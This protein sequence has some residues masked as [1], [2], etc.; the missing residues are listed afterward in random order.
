MKNNR[1]SANVVL[2]IMAVAF[3]LLG[4]GTV[5]GA[6]LQDLGGVTSAMKPDLSGMLMEKLGIKAP[7]AAGLMEKDNTITGEVANPAKL[8]GYGMSTNAGDKVGLT[9]LGGG[10]MGIQSLLGG[11]MLKLDMKDIFGEAAKFLMK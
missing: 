1:A 3:L 8:S 2:S 5:M 9:N 10:Q 11:D 7:D 4:A 6:G